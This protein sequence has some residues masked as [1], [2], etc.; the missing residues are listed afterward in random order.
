MANAVC[1]EPALVKAAAAYGRTSTLPTIWFYVAQRQLLRSDLASAM[2]QHG[3]AQAAA[4]APIVDAYAE[5]GHDIASDRA[6]WD[7]WGGGLERPSSPSPRLRLLRM[8]LRLAPAA[9]F[10]AVGR[11]AGQGESDQSR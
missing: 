10:R 7:L 11:G 9:R 2:A 5:D 1:G 4:R 3:P 6:G 8:P